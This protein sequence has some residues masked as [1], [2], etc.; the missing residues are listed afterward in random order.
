MAGPAAEK[1]ELGT[2]QGP[3]RR[4][5]L[6]VASLFG[7]AVVAAVGASGGGASPS[8]NVPCSTG[9]TGLI[10]AVNSANAAGGGTIN[11]DSGCTYP[12]TAADNNIMGGNGLPV[13]VT[14][15]ILNGK[16]ATIAGNN[17]SFRIIEV[18]GTSGGALTLNGITI[19]GGKVLGKMAAGAGGGILNVSGMLVLNGALVTH[20]F[21]ADAGGGIA[22]AF[23]ATATLNKSEVSW[24]TVPAGG[25]GGG[26]I[27]GLASTLTLNSSLVDHNTGPGGGGIASGNGMGGGPGSSIT[28]NKSVISNNTAIGNPMSGGG[29]ISNGGT[30]V[31]NN[32]EIIDNTAPGETGGGLLNHV[33]ATLNKTVV[34][35]NTAPTDNG[36]PGFGGGIVNAIFF[37]G[38]PAPTL[39][40]NNSTVTD[41]SASG[42]GGGILN[43]SFA[44]TAL[45]GT[46]TLHHT[47]VTSNTPENCSPLGS[48]D[49]CSG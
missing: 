48:I 23:G 1:G 36:N 25:S 6:A 26:G 13:V 33:T 12:L 3:C 21:G 47:S 18:D 44:A 19:T 27:L 4:V 20:N 42:D 43:V 17:S 15:I 49:G 31:S 16:D 11:L 35:G 28:L 9:G 45:P 7:A 34:S 39:E 37:D 32:S 40:L 24:N 22:N 8:T 10:A 5:G 46:V 14:P 41:N 38:Q 2:R 29:G 30:L